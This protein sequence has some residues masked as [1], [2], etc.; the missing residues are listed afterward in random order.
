MTRGH[1]C[2][3]KKQ[4]NEELLDSAVAEVI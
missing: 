1:K 4:I 3:F 2:D